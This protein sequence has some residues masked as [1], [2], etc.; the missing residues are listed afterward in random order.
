MDNNRILLFSFDLPVPFFSHVSREYAKLKQLEHCRRR[1]NLAHWHLLRTTHMTSSKK[2][3]NYKPNKIMHTGRDDNSDNITT[4][5]STGVHTATQ[6][7]TVAGTWSTATDATT[8]ATTTTTTQEQHVLFTK[9]FHNTD[10]PTILSRFACGETQ[11]ICC[12]RKDVK[13]VYA[14]HQTRVVFNSKEALET[15]RQHPPIWKNKHIVWEDEKVWVPR[16]SGSNHRSNSQQPRRSSKRSS[17][18]TNQGKGLVTSSA[19]APVAKKPRL[20]PPSL[21]TPQ[22]FG[23][24]GSYSPRPLAK[25]QP[26]PPVFNVHETP[27]GTD[28]HSHS[29]GSRQEVLDGG[30]KE[31]D[32]IPLMETS[33]S[34]DFIPLTP[35]TATIPPKSYYGS[36]AAVATPKQIIGMRE[37]EVSGSS[38][39]IGVE[40]ALRLGTGM[41]VVGIGSGEDNLYQCEEWPAGLPKKVVEV[42]AN[43]KLGRGSFGSVFQATLGGVFRAV[44]VV[45]L[46]RDPKEKERTM[47]K[48]KY[49]ALVM[50]TLTNENIIILEGYSMVDFKGKQCPALIMPEMACD[51]DVV[52]HSPDIVPSNLKHFFE[53]GKLKRPIMMKIASEMVEGLRAMHVDYNTLHGDLKPSNVLLNNNFDAKICDFSFSKIL[54]PGSNYA[55]KYTGEGTLSYMPPEILRGVEPLHPEMGG[56]EPLSKSSDIF[57]LGICFRELFSG[58]IPFRKCTKATTKRKIYQNKLPKMTTNM[59]CS[60]ATPTPPRLVKLLAWMCQPRPTDR[61]S[62]LQ[63]EGLLDWELR[64]SRSHLECF[65]EVHLQEDLMPCKRILEN[66]KGRITAERLQQIVNT[67]GEVHSDADKLRRLN[68]LCTQRWFVTGFTKEQCSKALF[69][70]KKGSFLVMLSS[71]AAGPRVALRLYFVNN[72]GK[73]KSEKIFAAGSPVISYLHFTKEGVPSQFPSVVELIR[74]LRHDVGYINTPYDAVGRT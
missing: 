15:A 21:L 30:K 4:S 53:G 48:L 41:G 5:G 17:T 43:G 35:L 6:T 59:A 38:V 67:F 27:T 69:R 64:D 73:V 24:P 36:S 62:I 40:A 46:P 2:I 66:S 65:R 16:A 60:P 72:D 63:V 54:E 42:N 3:R 56:H 44:K 37:L 8:T 23:T 39:G 68:E 47:K 51:L 57:S 61:P 9:A 12:H 11:L 71:E 25:P 52:I 55:N 1:G 70:E 20:P 58:K 26:P 49:E 19:A 50:S 45:Q 34:E 31:E 13:P 18:H 10:T 29:H 74:H 33:K 7:T 22:L 28:T 14:T 32:F